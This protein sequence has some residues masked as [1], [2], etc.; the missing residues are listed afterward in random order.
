MAHRPKWGGKIT[1]KRQKNI[2]LVNTCPC[3]NYWFALWALSK[4]QP[5][6]NALIPNVNEKPLLI[7]LIKLIDSLEWNMAKQHWLIEF[8]HSSLPIVSKQVDFWGSER[9]K[10]LKYI[11]SFQKYDLLQFCSINCIYNGAIITQTSIIY[12]EKIINVVLSLPYTGLCPNCGTR[13][14]CEINFSINEPNFIF[15]E[16]QTSNIVFDELPKELLIN[17]KRFKLLCGT[18]FVHQRNHYIGIIELN[19]NLYVIDGLREGGIITYL[20]PLNNCSNK[21]RIDSIMEN[22]RVLMTMSLYYLF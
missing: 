7:E 3:D 8:M 15:K 21:R 6:F 2:S 1:Y 5:N 12:F 9:G 10:F 14:N 4:L 11:E 17:N 16:S 19:N 20:P 22:H 18:G 13:I